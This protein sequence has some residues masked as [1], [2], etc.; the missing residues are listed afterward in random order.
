MTIFGAP[1]FGCHNILKELASV[2]PG[3]VAYACNPIA[4]GIE[5]GRWRI[6]SHFEL[7]SETLCLRQGYCGHDE[8][9]D[10]KQVREERVH[11]AYTSILVHHQRKSGQKLK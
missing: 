9:Q 3:V 11:L 4:Q 8:T 1:Y 10:Q 2:E 5:E 6:H 7:H